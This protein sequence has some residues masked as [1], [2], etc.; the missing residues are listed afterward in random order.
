MKR[1]HLII[2]SGPAGMTAL[3][4]IR[5]LAPDDD[6]T[7][8]NREPCL[9]YSPT[10][11]PYLLAKKV[12]M[13]HLW[14]ANEDYFKKLS[15]NY[16]CGKQV[17]KVIPDKNEVIYEDGE[18]EAYDRLLIATGSS[19]LKPTIDGIDDVGFLGYHTLHDNN[20]L[21]KQLTDKREVLLYGGGLVT[22]GLASSLI[23][24]GV[25]VKIV[26]RSRILRSYFNTN[27]GALIAEGFL[28]SGTDIIVGREIAHVEKTGR[29]VN[30]VLT[31]QTVI[32]GDLLVC[33]LGTQ[34]RVSFL[35]G[36]GISVN[37]GVRVGRRMETSAVNI[38]AAG[39]VAE[40]ED[41]FGASGV[42][43][44]VPNAVAQGDVAGDNMAGGKSR[45]SGWIPMNVFNYFGQTACSVGYSLKEHG[46]YRIVEKVDEEKKSSKRLVFNGNKLIGAMFVNEAIDPGVIRYLIE[47]GIDLNEYE[48]ILFKN[49]RDVSRWLMLKSEKE[50]SEPYRN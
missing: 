12:S 25:A 32:S 6:I 28:S 38:Y 47:R 44:I 34:P 50:N 10:A 45:F 8:V 37:T 21:E 26:V 9:P 49:P 42:N 36:S 7:M 18:H 46:D 11:L 19:P 31:D 24:R 2:G 17:D 23:R 39:D 1:K 22:M 15:C 5:K 43:A 13:Q 30:A 3:E 40:A 33:C 14:M 48:D 41:F 20:E 16:R 35:E 29:R 4:K 27:A